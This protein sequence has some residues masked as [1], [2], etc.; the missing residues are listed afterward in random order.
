LELLTETQYTVQHFEFNLATCDGIRAQALAASESESEFNPRVAVLRVN[1]TTQNVCSYHGLVLKG[2][3][4]GTYKSMPATT[5]MTGV[6]IDPGG[7]FIFEVTMPEPEPVRNRVKLEI[8]PG[9]ATMVFRG[10]RTPTD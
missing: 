1:N 8:A 4:E 3:L 5:D 2:F 7:S 6:H 10:Y 9:R